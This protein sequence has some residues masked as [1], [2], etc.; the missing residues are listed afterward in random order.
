MKTSTQSR[1]KAQINW[2]WLLV[3]IV[4]QATFFTPVTS[5][6]S[7]QISDAASGNEKDVRIAVVIGNSK[8]PSGALS[9]PR[10]DATAIF[11]S[12]KKLGFD[13]ELKMDATKDDMDE[14]FRRF[15]AKAARAHVA[16]MF[17]AGHG[18][19]VNGNN[20]IIP[21]DAKPKSERDLKRDMIKMDD[22]IDDMGDARVKLVFFD[23]CRDNPLAR[24]FNRGGSRGLAAP[25]EA[26]GT[27]ISFATKHGN[28]AADGEGEHSPYTKALLE[29]MENPS[30][31]EIEQMLRRIQQ[32]VRQA[33]NGQQEPWRYGSLDG[34]FYFKAAEAPPDTS[35]EQK[36]ALEKAISEAIQRANEQAARELQKSISAQKQATEQAVAEAIKRSKEQAA[37]ER[38]ELQQA[39]EKMLKD[40]L[41]R[42]NA[43]LETER[44]ARRA[45]NKEP[46]ISPPPLP[47][48]APTQA[49]KSQQAMQL[50]SIAPTKAMEALQP[51]HK[52]TSSISNAPGDEWE[53]R[54]TDDN[55][56]K[57]QT[58][59][60]RVMEATSEGVFEEILWNR[61]HYADWVFGEH[62]AALSTPND[63]AFMFSP[64]WNG[65]EL[66]E[67]LVKGEKGLC[68]V[69][70]ACRL[71][72]K[73]VGAEKL[74][75]AAGT[76][77]AIRLQGWINI[78]INPEGTGGSGRVT[79]WYSK[80]HRRLLKQSTDFKG[81]RTQYKE[82][83]ELAAMHPSS[84]EANSTASRSQTQ[85]PA[86]LSANA[87]SKSMEASRPLEEIAAS[88]SNAPGEE[89]EYQVTDELFGKKKQ[90]MMLRV[91]ASSSEGILEE[92]LWNGKPVE[93][94]VFSG[95]PAALGTPNESAFMFSPHWNGS[96]LSDIYVE[97]GTGRCVN[98]TRSCILSLKASGSEVLTVAA[99]TFDAIRLDGWV[100]IINDMGNPNSGRVTIWYSKE[101][102]RLLKQSAEMSGNRTIIYKE[103]LE[104]GAVR[105]APH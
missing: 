67:I 34:D 38:I 91:K 9:N 6:E 29:A 20:Y 72:L 12:L 79:I 82:T 87:T 81:G 53:Y 68:G 54:V 2:L 97:G 26:T 31:V 14:V 4:A 103:T 46:A 96:G 30:G 90:K 52:T 15:S 1:K 40:A 59:V 23:A 69:A 89:W 45:A 48:I 92:V 61:N 43:A 39:M 8:Y 102:R 51:L 44:L 28:T 57:K 100:R 60:L 83:I 95:Y 13:A 73:V 22:I 64:H 75:V 3:L 24:S 50:S 63:S 77:E 105:P 21:I 55:F 101:H 99:G 41:A 62:A 47:A 94:W 35:K 7:T 98:S 84:R 78:P 65:K 33:T 104:L 25:V 32:N 85:K 49:G 86:H 80:D 17:Y 27:L 66:P 16:L 76:F 42:Q 36:E 70:V 18:I 10:N 74:T 11:N 19:Q 88:L 71:D 56:G 5:A 37:R 58:L 93:E